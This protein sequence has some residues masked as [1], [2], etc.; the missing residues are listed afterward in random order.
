MRLTAGANAA[1]SWLTTN[2]LLRCYYHS[3]AM[4]SKMPTAYCQQLLCI[5]TLIL[6]Q[7]SV[8]TGDSL[9]PSTT[10]KHNRGWL[11][12]S[13]RGGGAGSGD[14]DD[15]ILHPQQSIS[16]ATIHSTSSDDTALSSQTSSP[17]TH[18]LLEETILHNGWRRL[19]NRKVRLPV[20]GKVADFEIVAQ[21][22]TDQA[23]LI[24]V[25]HSSTKT[26]TCIREY[27]PSVH[28]PMLGL[29]AGM[30]EDTKHSS[31]YNDEEEQDDACWMAAKCE[32]EEECRLTGGA[33]WFRLT[34]KPVVMD[35]YNTTRI[36]VFLVID[37][38]P[39]D[40]SQAKPRD[41]TEEGMQVIPNVTV[42][43]LR[44]WIQTGQM[45]I[46]GSWGTLLALQKL[47]ELGEID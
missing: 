14:D 1:S 5:A 15:D 8:T 29:A 12:A 2:N 23:V 34:E 41:D 37:P 26:A 21:R 24:F 6:A 4:V 19:I 36:I 45:T 43:Q 11:G 38:V 47:R 35:K 27:M 7:T 20:S 40:S 44:H 42:E 16:V 30:V 28:H 25:W 39:V 10:K 33:Q 17:P 13:W 22:G 9:F 18:K 3:K 46:V 32:L 31:S